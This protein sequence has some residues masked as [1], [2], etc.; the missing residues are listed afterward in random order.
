M[1]GAPA[2]CK[3]PLAVARHVYATSGVRGLFRGLGLTAARDMPAFGLYFGVYDGA[4]HLMGMHV[5]ALWE[6]EPGAAAA[7][8]RP[9]GSNAGY[10]GD[11]EE[12]P[13]GQGHALEAGESEDMARGDA[14]PRRKRQR[15]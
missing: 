5:P 8:A 3:G 10:H 2:G 14:Q 12:Q 11:G 13:Q 4:K 9:S 7:P 6:G 1:G 15:H